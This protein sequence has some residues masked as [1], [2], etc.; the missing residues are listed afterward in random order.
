MEQ[1][2]R[3]L[4]TQRR[5]GCRRKTKLEDVDVDV[6][7]IDERW[8]VQRLF[9]RRHKPSQ[10]RLS[11]LFCTSVQ[12]RLPWL[13]IPDSSTR[14]LLTCIWL[15][16]P[17]S[18]PTCDTRLA[19]AHKEDTASHISSTEAHKATTMSRF[20]P[21]TDYAEDQPMSHTV[22]ITHVLYRGFQTGAVVGHSLKLAKSLFKKSSI[23]RN[24]TILA[25]TLRSTGV[26]ALTGTALMVPGIYMRM[27][28]REE[29]EWKD[30][31][32]RLLEHE[33][34]KAVDDCSV[35]GT[36]FGA[37]FGARQIASHQSARTKI[38]TLAGGAGVGSIAG[39]IVYLGWWYGLKGGEHH[40][41]ER[42]VV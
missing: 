29:I 34:Q 1:C 28:G 6:D 9:P 16:Q 26:G 18:C 35:V 7:I 40:V 36:V 24:E 5:L 17:V 32:W 27:R 4:A 11:P 13:M 15:Y 41:S 14:A 33:G 19:H 38:F 10:P 25:T 12:V 20:F 21:H 31:S 22:L 39:V 42:S 3:S 2:L 8:C 37:L 23:M 30:R